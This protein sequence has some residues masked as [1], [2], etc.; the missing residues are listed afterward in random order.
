ME[1]IYQFVNA[2]KELVSRKIVH[3]DLKPDNIF[4]SN[5]I[6]KIGDFGLSKQIEQAES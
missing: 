4:L 1:F 3:R 2:Y 5:E 6:M